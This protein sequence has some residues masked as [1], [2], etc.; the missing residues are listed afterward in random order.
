MASCLLSLQCTT[1]L[2]NTAPSNFKTIELGEGYHFQF[3]SFPHTLHT[4]CYLL[5]RA[6][7]QLQLVGPSSPDF[8]PLLV[9]GKE[10]SGANTTRCSLDFYHL[11]PP[12]LRRW[13]SRDVVLLSFKL[14]DSIIQGI[15]RSYA[16]TCPASCL[17]SNQ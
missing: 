6:R 1:T 9:A 16:L 10:R 4:H 15:P 11:L 7:K 17:T 14:I 12:R 2:L 5:I 3:W 8:R 13:Q